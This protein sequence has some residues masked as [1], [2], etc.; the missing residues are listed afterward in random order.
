MSDTDLINLDHGSLSTMT[1]NI[2]PASGYAAGMFAPGG[3]WLVISWR[4]LGAGGGR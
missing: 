1:G 3:A 2:L 4:L